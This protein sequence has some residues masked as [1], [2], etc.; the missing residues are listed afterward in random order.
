MLY[1]LDYRYLDGVHVFLE[2]RQSRFSVGILKKA[3]T[4]YQFT[5]DKSY[6][7]TKRAIPLGP[8]CRKWSPFARQFSGGMR[9]IIW[10]VKNPL[11]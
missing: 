4:G 2:S 9:D 1:N 3:G 8:E 5:Y 10:V 7:N 6:L 11:F